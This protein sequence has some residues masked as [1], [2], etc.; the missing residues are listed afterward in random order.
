MEATIIIVL[1]SFAWMGNVDAKSFKKISKG[2]GN[3]IFAPKALLFK[4]ERSPAYKTVKTVFSAPEEVFVR[5]YFPKNLKSYTSKGKIYN[6]LRNSKISFSDLVA[7]M[8]SEEHKIT[9]IEHKFDNPSADQQSFYITGKGD[10]DFSISAKN[11]KKW[12]ATQKDTTGS[13][14]RYCI[15]FPALVRALGAKHS[16]AEENVQFCVKRYFSFADK[17]RVKKV[18]D[19]KEKRKKSLLEN[20]M[21]HYM[22]SQSCFH[23]KNRS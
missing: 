17:T 23:Y 22:L 8:N 20:D 18:W 5:C 15:N 14:N 21:K 1:A 16:L 3:C 10:C 19:K 13:P 2:T 7:V 6:S 11:A 12:G 9:G 4:K